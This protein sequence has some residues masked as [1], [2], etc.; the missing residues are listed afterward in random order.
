K[1]YIVGVPLEDEVKHSALE[2]L[3]AGFDTYLIKNACKGRSP[4]AEAKALNEMKN[5]GVNLMGE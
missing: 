3:Q 4:E 5:A 2:S 1:L